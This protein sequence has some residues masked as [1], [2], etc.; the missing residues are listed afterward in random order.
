VSV[1]LGRGRRVSPERKTGEKSPVKTMASGKAKKTARVTFEVRGA[2]ELTTADEL[3]V[4]ASTKALEKGIKIPL[5]TTPVTAIGEDAGDDVDTNDADVSDNVMAL[6]SDD[7]TTYLLNRHPD[8]TVDGVRPTAAALRLLQALSLRGNPEERGEFKVSI[9][10]KV[11]KSGASGPRV[12]YAMDCP[13]SNVDYGAVLSNLSGECVEVLALPTTVWPEA[14]EYVLRELLHTYST[15]G[16]TMEPLA[17]RQANVAASGRGELLV[18]S[19]QRM[20]DLLAKRDLGKVRVFT[21]VEMNKA[22]KELGR[23]GYDC[24]PNYVQT[25]ALLAKV[26]K[27]IQNF[28]DES[29][30]YKPLLPS[31][32]GLQ[33]EDM[34]HKSSALGKVVEVEEVHQIGFS[35]RL[36]TARAVSSAVK[37]T[38]TL[39]DVAKKN[40][41]WHMVLILSVLIP[42][43]MLCLNYVVDEA[44][45]FVRPYKISKLCNLLMSIRINNMLTGEALENWMMTAMIHVQEKVNLPDVAGAAWSG[46][47]CINYLTTEL[48]RNMSVAIASASQARME[49]KSVAALQAQKP[50]H[51]LQ[52]NTVKQHTQAP[53]GKVV[54]P[55]C[56]AKIQNE[57]TRQ[58]RLDKDKKHRLFAWKILRIVKEVFQAT[59][60]QGDTALTI[61]PFFK[62]AGRGNERIWGEEIST[63]QPTVIKLSGLEEKEKLHL[64]PTLSAT[65]NWILLTQPL[66]VTTKPSP[67]SGWSSW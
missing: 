59:K 56:L 42:S 6:G 57:L 28:D 21:V 39:W 63:P 33:A 15:G 51:S 2:G 41:Y 10:L 31:E 20:V 50:K 13:R 49:L 52:N 12:I 19:Q 43:G 44:G 35:D 7:V 46:N 62:N 14:G 45:L 66:G 16:P 36:L 65:D 58:L 34:K 37:T 60:Y 23:L 3:G 1:A 40:L 18:A 25:F 30:S 9:T 26:V 11:Q 47:M 4:E 27:Y 64:I 38:R 32:P 48:N 5:K 29:N 67:P 53:R 61:P 24:S 22:Y 17:T 8:K 55:K 54:L